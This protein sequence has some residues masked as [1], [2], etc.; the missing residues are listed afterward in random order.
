ML[1]EVALGQRSLADYTHIA[2]RGLIEQIREL[3]EPL[4]GK[5]VLHVSATAFGG[6][7]SEIL[8]TLV[9]LMRDVGLDAHWQVIL[10]REEFFNVTKLMHNSL[11]GDPQAIDDEQWE[12]FEGYNAMNAQ[13]PRGGLGRDHRTRPAAGRAARERAR[14]R[15]AL[16]LA[17]PHRPLDPEPGDPG[18][19]RC[20]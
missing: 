13:E 2:G 3:A 4:Q 19:P 8:Y 1:Q 18:A 6:G 15:A 5:R 20:R 7:V 9:P 11:Q 12:V 10:G 16:D 14:P 17:L